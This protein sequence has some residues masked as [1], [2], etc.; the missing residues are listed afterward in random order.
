MTNI[1]KKT[2]IL[3]D[4][5]NTL[6]DTFDAIFSAQN[7]ML[8]FYGIPKLT[9]DDAIKSMNKSWRNIMKELIGEEKLVEARNIY[10]DAY[11]K[12][13]SNLTFKQGALDAL[14]K[15]NELQYI[16][17]LAS[18]KAG[19]ILRDE[20]KRLDVAHYFDYI[21]GA[22]DT[23]HH[24]P[25]KSFT[26]VALSNFN[27][28]KIYSIGDRLADIKMGHNYK[29]GYAILVGS[30]PNINEFDEDKPDYVFNDM[31]GVTNFLEKITKK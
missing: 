16:N 4:W 18:N 5:D 3:W 8:N 20:V 9:K 11:K 24:K 2:V 29:N 17:I 21:I 10:L 7:V 6:V 14:K 22:E 28:E 12:N 19:D 23:P 15:A 30:I 13:S 27:Y 31:I 1:P 25:S 26:D